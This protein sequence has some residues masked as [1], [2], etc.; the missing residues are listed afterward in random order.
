VGGRKENPAC[1]PK[2][3]GVA[4]K[5]EVELPE[6]GADAG[7]GELP[8]VAVPNGSPWDGCSAGTAAGADG[9]AAGGGPQEKPLKPSGAPLLKTLPPCVGVLG[10]P[11]API[12]FL[13]RTRQTIERQR[14]EPQRAEGR[15]DLQIETIN[16]RLTSAGGQGEG[17]L[18]ESEQCT[19]PRE[20]IA[21]RRGNE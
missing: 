1:G 16:Q 20:N 17:I 9:C 10:I 14:R 3:K 7:I 11:V 6:V 19:V 15:S 5:T 21:E 12:I 18:R 4:P 13:G 2:V 8:A